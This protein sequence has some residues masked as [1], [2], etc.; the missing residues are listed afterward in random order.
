MK[1]CHVT[2]SHSRYDGRIF[3][4]E[5]SSLAKKYDVTLICSDK[6][7]DEIKNNV[8]IKS[9]GIDNKSKK[10]RFLLIPMKL[11]KKCLVED[12]D[13]YHFHDP[14]LLSLASYMKRKNKVVIFDSHEDNLNRI[15][16][17]TWI[18]NFL[19]PLAKKFYQK[20]EKK[21]LER[22]DD[23]ITVTEHIYDRLVR[24]N[25]NT[26]I[27]T[28]FP[29][30]KN[31]NIEKK[32]N[33]DNIICFAGGVE[34]KYMHHNIIKALDNLNVQ[35][36]VAGPCSNNYYDE[37]KKISGF[38]KVKFLGQISREECNKLYLKSN[39][40]MV[41]IDYVPN[42]NFKK[43]SM[44]ITKIFEYMEY[45]LPVIATDL[46]VWK[47]IVPNKCGICVN[48]Y[49]IEEIHDAIKFL[50]DNPDKAKEMGRVGQRLV[51]EKYNWNSQEKIL[52]DLYKKY[53]K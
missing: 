29:I 16:N 22:V 17:R 11:R 45:G 25:H 40:G 36:I 47:E 5:C 35:Y 53:D 38:N 33:S 48:P 7:Q 3:Q 46:E 13:I 26:H 39:I 42:I 10:N 52:L 37:L 50:V 43:G 51:K 18:P 6:N 4:K 9:V 41:L 27:I 28:N 49:N 8:K 34:K 12:A 15:S 44:G 23:I 19:K 21:V 2:S 31:I 20:K 24:I 1:I 30:L 14:E 32:D